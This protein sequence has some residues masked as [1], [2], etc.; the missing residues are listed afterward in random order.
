MRCLLAEDDPDIS[1]NLSQ[2]LIRAGYTV[3]AVY[4]GREAIFNASEYSYA[5]AIVD[6]GLPLNDGM[7]VIRTIRAS[8]R[9]LPIIV[10]TA[11]T[12]VAQVVA[13]LEA[14]ADDYLKKPVEVEEVLAHIDAVLRRA[15]S[16]THSLDPVMRHSVYQLD[17]RRR[18]LMR[19]DQLIELTTAEIAILEKLWKNAGRVLSKREIAE[20]YQKDPDVETSVN[21]VEGLVGRLKKK[22]ENKD[23]GF[24][25]PIETVR[26]QGYLFDD[27][28]DE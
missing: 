28:G 19:Q 27:L 10:L 18:E 25:L 4:D 2:G 12:Q 8:G 22:C 26:G 13:A 3:D 9:A 24:R 23:L 21:S 14:G 20:S 7:Q 15:S 6:L 1:R 16:E 5:I 17:V 11:R